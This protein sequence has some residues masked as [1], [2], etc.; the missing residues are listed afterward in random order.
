MPNLSG[1]NYIVPYSGAYQLK[2]GDTT[3][4]N[5]FEL[6]FSFLYVN[7]PFQ[8]YCDKYSNGITSG[9]ITSHNVG[10][11]VVINIAYKNGILNIYDATAKRYI[12]ENYRLN[13]NALYGVF[14]DNL[15]TDITVLNFPL[16][17]K[18]ID[19]SLRNNVFVNNSYRLEAMDKFYLYIIHSSNTLT[20]TLKFDTVLVPISE[21]TELIVEYND[22]LVSIKDKNNTN[23]SS[24][25]LTGAIAAEISD[26]SDKITIKYYSYNHPINQLVPIPKTISGI[27]YRLSIGYT[28]FNDK[29]TGFT[30]KV[31]DTNISLTPATTT[32]QIV[33]IIND[34]GVL[35]DN[36]NTIY[37]SSVSSITL[38]DVYNKIDIL[39]Y[40]RDITAEQFFPVGTGFSKPQ[41]NVITTIA[42]GYLDLY[43][44]YQSDI[45]LTFTIN[46][47]CFI[48]FT[49]GNSKEIT[50]PI[51]SGRHTFSLIDEDGMLDNLGIVLIPPVKISFIY[52]SSLPII[53]IIDY[54]NNIPYGYGNKG[55][56]GPPGVNGINGIC[57]PGE[58]GDRGVKGIDSSDGIEGDKGIEGFNP[59][60]GR[61]GPYF[62]GK[63]CFIQSSD[64]YNLSINEVNSCN[65]FSVID[66]HRFKPSTTGLYKIMLSMTM[67]NTTQVNVSLINSRG[68]VVATRNFP[69]SLEKT[70][71]NWS[72]MTTLISDSNYLL[73]INGNYIIYGDTLNPGVI[74]YI[75]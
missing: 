74:I 28:P 20:Y 49:G 36:Y 31:N 19:E 29:T 55:N 50:K 73:A 54:T 53:T 12:R 37:P 66:I 38:N 68:I 43:P 52:S 8:W 42:Y 24:F 59:M 17:S 13:A 45:S 40:N 7:N 6:S 46:A 1:S 75:K 67:T 33:H 9:L 63:T 26:I 32:Y 25:S 34:Y 65:E 21:T 51:T 18:I 60:R 44:L 39:A 15:N 56:R 3:D 62:M 71:V 72:L 48:K 11:R 4:F 2:Y 57:Y 41:K 70:I 47:D 16:E 35:S 5:A 69:I 61:A 23:I 10:D 30:M 27:N 22:S 58:Q 14:F 64:L